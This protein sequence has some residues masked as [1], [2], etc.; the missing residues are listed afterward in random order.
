VTCGRQHVRAPLPRVKGKARYERNGAHDKAQHEQRQQEEAKAGPSP[1]LRAGRIPSCRSVPRRYPVEMLDHLTTVGT[2]AQMRFGL[3]RLRQSEVACDEG[4]ED[5]T[6]FVARHGSTSRAKSVPGAAPAKSG[7]KAANSARKRRRRK[8]F[9]KKQHGATVIVPAGITLKA[10]L[11]PLVG[12]SCP[13]R[14][15]D[16]AYTPVRDIG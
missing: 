4:R 15:V 16:S 10:R 11:Q 14:A 3:G 6:D 12:S 9:A 1:G 7:Q 13:A 5:L 8:Q 2:A